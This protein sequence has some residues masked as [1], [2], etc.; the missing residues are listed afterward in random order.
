MPESK[1][2]PYVFSTRILQPEL[3][4]QLEKAGIKYREQDFIKVSHEFNED[5]F[6][7]SLNNPETQARVFTSKNAVH[8]LRLLAKSQPLKIE[9]KKTFTVG[10]RATQMLEEEFGLKTSAR[11]K[12]AISLAQI[13]ARNGDVGAV[14]FFCGNQSLDDLP[15]YLESKGISVNREIVYKTELV[16]EEIE[17]SQFS[18]MI[19]LSPTAVYSF[20]KKNRINPEIPVFC[21]GAT[22]AEAVHL[23]CNNPRIESDEP[24]IESVVDKVIEY[25]KQ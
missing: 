15:E 6:L 19:F 10:I 16:Q 23:R 12:N 9:T 21:I 24:L 4:Q 25:F 5:S 8:S 11:A 17:T 13:I 2:R 20:F 22:T 14:D 7:H 18:G 3:G 1:P